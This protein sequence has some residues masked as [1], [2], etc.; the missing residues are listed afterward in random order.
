LIRARIIVEGRV[1]RVGYRDLVER[2]ARNLGVKGYV[3]NLRDGNVQIV[4]EA[5]ETVLERFVKE[6]DVKEDFVEVKRVRIVERSEATGEFENFE[7][8]YGRLEEEFGERMGTAI[9][10]AKAMRGD[11]T[12]MH[13]DLK[14]GI[15]GIKEGVKAMHMDIKK[16]H[17]DLK[18]EIVGVRGEVRDMHKD[19]KDEI[20]GVRGEVRDMHTDMNKSFGEM[21]ERYD[22][23]SSEL[24]RT[25]EELTRAVNGLLKLIEEFIH[26]RSGAGLK[27]R[28]E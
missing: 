19:L 10:Y 23:I 15:T 26:E 13:K 2:V 6:I 27:E 21:A 4:C 14:E 18:E 20:V 9:E 28:R 25:R 16:M 17:K 8:R 12:D 1:Q 5:E 3:E 7:I 11:L 24:I 22:A